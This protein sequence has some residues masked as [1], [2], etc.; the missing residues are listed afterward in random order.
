MSIKLINMNTKKKIKNLKKTRNALFLKGI[1]LVGL[2]IFLV[3]FISSFSNYWI[4][5]GTV[6]FWFGVF[7]ICSGVV[8]I[9]AELSYKRGIDFGEYLK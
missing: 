6:V 9:I 1:I 7:F 8:Y 4:I 5:I 2:S 3:F